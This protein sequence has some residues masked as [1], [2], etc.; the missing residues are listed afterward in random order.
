MTTASA[1]RQVATNLGFAFL[2]A[3]F[4]FASIRLADEFLAAEV[5]GLVLL[6]RRQ[7]ALWANLLQLGMSQSLRKFYLRSSDQSVR[8]LLWVRLVK[9]VTL[10][11][12]AAFLFCVAF[13]QYVGI[14]LFS[15]P[16]PAIA[17]IFALYAGAIALG[18]MASS[19]WLVEFRFLQY[20][21]IDWLN[22]SAIFVLLLLVGSQWSAT[23]LM[24]MLALCSI[25]AS[26]ISLAWFAGT[27]IGR[28]AISNKGW[29][30]E[31]EVG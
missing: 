31:S 16:D 22:G 18:F 9:W 26:M 27:F 17:W 19:S 8:R 5:M 29:A 6:F 25:A 24:L 3:S 12:C 23:N 15:E 20:N 21:V 4:V 10:S 28:Q 1:R 30:I 11:S 14:A 2:K 7:G 13:G